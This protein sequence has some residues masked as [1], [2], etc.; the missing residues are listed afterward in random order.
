DGLLISNNK[1]VKC[2]TNATSV[3]IPEGVTSIGDRAFE[4]CSSLTSITIPDGI[5]SIGSGAFNGTPWYDELNNKHPDDVIYIGE[6]AYSYN[7]FIDDV[8]IKEGTKCIAAWA[9][10][11]CNSMTAITIPEGVTNIGAGA[12]SDCGYLSSIVIPD[13]VKSIERRTFD[14]CYSL[15]ELVIPESVTY[16]GDE[17]FRDCSSLSAIIL[18]SRVEYFG[19]N[20]FDGCKHLTSIDIPEGVTGIY[21]N[22][23]ES[24]S[25][26][27]IPSS[28]KN[29]SA[30]A[31]PSL[32]SIDVNDDNP[33]YAS[34]DGVLYDKSLSTL[35]RLPQA[36]QGSFTV[37]NGTQCI[38]DNAFS[39]CRFLTSISMPEGL[40][41]IGTGA[42]DY[43]VSLKTIYLPS[44]LETFGGWNFSS[45]S[46]LRH[47]VCLADNPPSEFEL[48]W[49][50][51]LTVHVPTGSKSAYQEGCLDIEVVEGADN[52]VHTVTFVNGDEV[53][54]TEELSVGEEITLPEDQEREGLIFTGWGGV[55]E[56]NL[57][58]GHDLTISA[59]YNA[60]YWKPIIKNGDLEGE[61]TDNLIAH[62]RSHDFCAPE[63]ENGIGVDGSRG[64]K[65]VV[66]AMVWTNWDSQFFIKLNQD[67]H[68]GDIVKFSMDIKASENVENNPQTQAYSG[69]TVFNSNSCV[70]IPEFT[71]EWQ[72]YETEIT[73]RQGMTYW[74]REFNVIAFNLSNND[75]AVTYYFDN[76]NVSILKQHPSNETPAL[77][78]LHELINK[79]EDSYNDARYN[80][81][82]GNLSNTQ[83]SEN[84]VAAYE[85]AVEAYDSKSDL[86]ASNAVETLLDTFEDYE[87]S[88]TDYREC[89]VKLH[90]LMEY[91][92][93]LETAPQDLLDEF[94][95]YVENT[96]REI[97][98]VRELT[99]EDIDNTV[100]PGAMSIIAKYMEVK[101]GADISYLFYNPNFKRG[102]SN[103]WA[104]DV[105]QIASTRNLI[106]GNNY[107]SEYCTAEP[108]QIDGL[109]ESYHQ[110]VNVHQT[111]KNLSTGIYMLSVQ[112]FD[113]HDFGNMD[114][115]QLYV[116]F[117]N[118]QEQ[119]VNIMDIETGATQEQL[120]NN[121]EW[122][123]DTQL[124][125]GLFVPNSTTGAAW[126]FVN[127]MD[128]KH[129]DY[130]NKLV[131]EMEEPG[132]VVIGVR[133]P[134]NEQWVTIDNFK[135]FYASTGQMGDAD[136]DGE[137][138]ESD[139]ATIADVIFTE[140]N[141]DVTCMY[142]DLN[143]DEQ[144]DVADLAALAYNLKYANGVNKANMHKVIS[145]KDYDALDSDPTTTGNTIYTSNV[146][147]KAGKDVQLTINLRNDI[148]TSGYQFDLS[149]PEGISVA[150]DG[151]GN[152][153]V[154]MSTSRTT[155]DAMT[156]KGS[157]MPDGTLR[158]LCYSSECE[159]LS[160]NDGEICNITLHV[161]DE[162][163]EGNYPVVISEVVLTDITGRDKKTSDYMKSSLEV[164][165]GSIEIELV[166][167][168]PYTNSEDMYCDKITYTRTFKNTNW[169]AL[170]V[171]FDVEVTDELLER[172][173]FSKFAG[174]YTDEDEFYLTVASLKS[175]DM[176]YAN[177]PYFIRAKVADSTN[178]QFITVQ[179]VILKAAAVNPLVMLSAEKRIEI[180][181]IY[182]P[183]TATAE[184]CDWYA[185]GSGKYIHATVGQ[186]LGAE[187]FFMTIKDREDNPYG[188][189][190]NPMEVKMYFFGDD[191]TAMPEIK[192]E[193]DRSVSEYYNLQGVRVNKPMQSNIYIVNGKKIL[194]K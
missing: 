186:K 101:P 26:I 104:S 116:K 19:S 164:L 13:G 84:Y 63:I 140:N 187:R 73:V 96:E 57:M 182:S 148:A 174:T 50:E 155:E 126:H 66:P 121:R 112:S 91:L 69:L 24:L 113:R 178:P 142:A 180:I 48:A 177:T 47:I 37:P 27:Y 136:G 42:F 8:V 110:A 34:V 82:V 98:D 85:N 17:A 25:S 127:K 15:T 184:D 2:R 118:G 30:D 183:K 23:C 70:G 76:I 147:T 52:L 54:Y 53:L 78:E 16:I 89:M 94:A 58:P 3:T 40:T 144:F 21:F 193:T 134:N 31:L 35:L 81:S 28:V 150:E 7:G 77:N 43:C 129:Y 189:R 109:A 194:F 166:D 160:G 44:T 39:G 145:E 80:W 100:I 154:T 67:L 59:E 151:D 153:M 107:N 65:V 165:S 170:Y 172:F 9:F 168:T 175:G 61:K 146:S 103:C 1:V 192:P 93:D 83:V 124:D 149:L 115:A 88:V 111:I 36:Y 72:H 22:G 4:G 125:N 130:T 122:S 62:V 105:S 64:I 141:P 176:I 169:Q 45:C 46:N 10:S 71:T 191:E 167:G 75:H 108:V 128:G 157:F 33:K 20:V 60:Y 12:F 123:S 74:N 181:G 14:R 139:L 159:T 133:V 79:H 120:Y 132:D 11:G 114:C 137:V 188:A 5:T 49:L 179:N 117:A 6:I 51:K 102:Y 171:P 95:Q 86:L 152:P 162:V 119:A 135:L 161:D 38:G 87:K 97:V 163:C 190:P 143:D 55:P 41:A 18:P 68:V 92:E 173:S 99:S 185:Y 90:A 106:N 156:F 158:V 29:I 131:F 32:A 138:D 56:F